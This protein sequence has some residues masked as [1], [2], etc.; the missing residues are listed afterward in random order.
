MSTIVEAKPVPAHIFDA[1]KTLVT[2]EPEAGVPQAV[3]FLREY[4][5]LTQAQ[6]A[7]RFRIY[8]SAI[9]NWETGQQLPARGRTVPI[10]RACGIPQIVIDQLVS[11]DERVKL[12][13]DAYQELD[14]DIVDY[15]FFQA[16]RPQVLETLRDYML[17]GDMQAARIYVDWMNR[18][19]AK[20]AAR[21]SGA[22]P[23]SDSAQS[24]RGRA[25]TMTKASRRITETSKS[26]DT[27]AVD[28]TEPPA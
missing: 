16:N 21:I 2:R 27:Q 11:Y 26:D 24:L 7:Q 5:Q 20:I 23:V 1:C 17:D 10:L 15:D 22:I 18:T 9:A 13:P 12:D 4:A 6:L 14:A 28:N 8:R 19:E 3:K 25:I